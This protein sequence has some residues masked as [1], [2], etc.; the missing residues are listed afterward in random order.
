M[1]QKQKFRRLRSELTDAEWY[2]IKQF[3]PPHKDR[4]R[5]RANDRKTLNGI[6]YVL[7]TGCRW[8]DLPPERYGSY[9][10]CWRRFKTWQKNGY[11][12]KI[13]VNLLRELDRKGKLNL[14]N[15]YLDSSVRES[16]KG[17]NNA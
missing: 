2:F 1:T 3:L 13:A 12:E 16:K 10:T 5:P 7:S 9:V 6:L 17:V 11:W 15:S 8:E 4:G 14:R